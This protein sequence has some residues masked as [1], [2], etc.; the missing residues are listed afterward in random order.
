MCIYTYMYK[1]MLIH[2]ICL[3]FFFISSVGMKGLEKC[4]GVIYMHTQ[5]FINEIE[6]NIPPLARKYK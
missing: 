1:C 4:G 6:R 5:V 3:R 2:H